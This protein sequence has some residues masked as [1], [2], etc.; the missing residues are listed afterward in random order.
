MS[1][2]STQRPPRAVSRRLAPVLLIFTLVFA[3]GCA[4]PTASTTAPTA[5][6]ADDAAPTQTTAATTATANSASATD[7]AATAGT[8]AT[9]GATTP[10]TSAAARPGAAAPN[11]VTQTS[12]TSQP[13]GATTATTTTGALATIESL[14]A[15]SFERRNAVELALEF[16][17]TKSGERVARTSPLPDQVGSKTTFWISNI[18][19]DKYY[20]TTATLRLALDHVLMYVEDGV[21]YRQ[22]DL[23]RSARDF[24]DKIYPRNRELFGSEWTPG[25]DGDPRIT[26]LNARIS[27]AGGYFSSSDEVPRTVNRFSNEREMF[28]MNVESYPLGSEGYSSVL[29]HE[30]QHM[31]E[32]PQAKDQATWSNEGLS[33]LAMELNGYQPSGAAPA[34]LGTPDLQLTA[35]GEDPNTSVPHYGAAYLFLSYF[36]EH[37]GKAI[38]FGELIRGGAGRHL[39][40][41]ADQARKARPDLRSFDELFA[42]WAVANLID[43]KQ[44]EGGRWSYKSLPGPVEPQQDNG[45]NIDGSVAQYAAD[46]LALPQTSSRRVLNFDGGDAIRLVNTQPQGK[47]SWWSNRADDSVSELTGRFDLTKVKSATL[48]FKTWFDI[49]QGYDYGYVSASTDDGKTWTTLKGRHTTTED[50]QGANYGNGYT[51]VS[52]QGQPGW[53]DESI[54]LTP[55]AGKNV[56]LRFSLITDDAFNKP[57][58]LIDDI[59]IPEINF[60]DDAEQGA[61]VWQA[62]GWVRT[63]NELPQRWQLRLVRRTGGQT[64]V[65]P[66]AL[67]GQNRATINVGAGERDVLVVMATTPHTEERASYTIRP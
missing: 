36:Y 46:Y 25:I 30:F 57:G 26:V 63:G 67:D 3:A 22:A 53:V 15:V 32:W 7:I 1:P 54:D 20:T 38:N 14:D 50:P 65:E 52:G 28:Y 51:G 60:T 16:G 23:E 2:K 8:G 10:A 37:Y 29:A 9:T 18:S 12:E 58:M 47:A 5:P 49:E 13:A 27:G 45:K 59:R 66:V 24:N 42:D 40:L 34:F 19:E 48:Q 4:A 21:E 43:D 31:I 17:K 44:L 11:V 41:L 62:A 55:F 6:R 61:G 56:L 39:N 33:E 64:T 35:W